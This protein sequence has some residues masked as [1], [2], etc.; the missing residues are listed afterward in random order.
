[1]LTHA[2]EAMVSKNS[3]DFSDAMAEKAIKL[4]RSH[5]MTVYEN[6]SNI[7]A[8]Q[9]MHN[10]SCLAGLAFNN[11]GLGLNHSMA[12]ALGAQFHIPHGKANAVLDDRSEERRVGKECRSRWSPYH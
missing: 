11:A 10:A 9:A 6:S 3:T 2:I 8:R 4:I 7:E 5:L 1:M 12:H